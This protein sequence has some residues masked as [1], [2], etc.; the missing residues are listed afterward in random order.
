MNEQITY[1]IN[2]NIHC[3]HFPTTLTLGCVLNS[4]LCHSSTLTT[5]NILGLMNYGTKHFQ[6]AGLCSVHLT[7]VKSLLKIIKDVTG[8]SGSTVPCINVISG[9]VQCFLLVRLMIAQF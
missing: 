3:F 1:S 7:N 9:T 8:V 4:M 2:S 6:G 5:S